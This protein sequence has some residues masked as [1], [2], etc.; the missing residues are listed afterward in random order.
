MAPIPLRDG[1]RRGTA[2]VGRAYS[3]LV[4]SSW[5]RRRSSHRRWEA[6]AYLKNVQWSLWE[7]RSREDVSASASPAMKEGG[8]HQQEGESINWSSYRLRERWA[9]VWQGRQEAQKG[10]SVSRWAAEGQLSAGF[11]RRQGFGG[12][13]KH[14]T[15]GGRAMG[16][17]RRGRRRATPLRGRD[18]DGFRDAKKARDRLRARAGTF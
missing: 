1:N 12:R 7:R 5:R 6:E 2:S 13:R 17:R 11:L 8:K 10:M 14:C 18:G 9:E 16:E 4:T 15:T 3:I